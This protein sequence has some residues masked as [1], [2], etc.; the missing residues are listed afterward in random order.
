MTKRV[1][2]TG[3]TGQDCSYLAELLL[4]KRPRG[5]RPQAPL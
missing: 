4:K 5:A 2:I 3:P 1:L